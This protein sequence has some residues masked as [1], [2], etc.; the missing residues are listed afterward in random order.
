MSRY[1]ETDPV[2]AFPHVGIDRKKSMAE[3]IRD[4]VRSERMAQMAMEAGFETPEEADDFDVGDDVD[5]SSDYEFEEVF[6]PDP[7]HEDDGLDRRLVAA[8]RKA[9]SLPEDAESPEPGDQSDQK[10]KQNEEV[11]NET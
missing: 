1:E 4:M 6:E 10:T 11:A 5:P 2:P 8:L 9:L 7:M 3:Q